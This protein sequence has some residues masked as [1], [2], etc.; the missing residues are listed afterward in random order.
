VREGLGDLIV[1]CATALI[2]TA[3]TIPHYPSLALS[4]PRYRSARVARFLEFMSRPA[5]GPQV[6][7]TGLER[8]VES[9]CVRSPRQPCTQCASRAN[10]EA[11]AHASRTQPSG[12]L[13]TACC[14]RRPFSH[15]PTTTLD[16]YT[17]TQIT[18]RKHQH[19]FSIP[20]CVLQVRERW[21]LRW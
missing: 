10:D 13:L 16:A 12:A 17:L 5:D 18:R 6:K 9:R 8:R 7:E 3:S 2:P 1:R 11:I 14:S 15:P 20:S 21:T 4:A 19:V